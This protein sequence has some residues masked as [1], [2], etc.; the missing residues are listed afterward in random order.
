MLRLFITLTLLLSLTEARE[1]LVSWNDGK[2]KQNIVEFVN[3]VTDPKSSRFVPVADR[4][5]VF[6]NDGTLWSEK[7]MYF[8]FNFVLDRVKELA[9]DHPE[10]Q[11]NKLFKAAIDGDMKTVLSFGTKGLIELAVATHSD[12]SVPE[13]QKEVRRWLKD[14][15]HPR[16]DRPYSDLIYQPMME[17]ITYLEANDFKVYIVSGGGIDFMRAFIPALYELPAEQIIGSSVAVEYKDGK[18]IKLPKINFI[19]DK[20]TKP[21]AINYHIGKRP[22]AAFG[23]SDGD[24]AMMQY[25]DANRAETLQLYV[26]HTDEKREWAYDRNSHVGKLDKGLD[27]ALDHRWTVVDMKKDWK[28][29]YPFELNPPKS[30]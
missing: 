14:A 29:V 11:K 9:E 18:I 16:F 20:E 24:L 15:K 8:Q 23:N 26:H 17:L 21:V 1:Y 28:V 2:S 27:Y 19:D 25:T 12:M 30:K 7:P 22:I 5:A 13:Y 4:I 6:D 3:K 10:W